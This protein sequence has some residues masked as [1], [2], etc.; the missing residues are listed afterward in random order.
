MTDKSMSPSVSPASLSKKTGVRRVNNLPIFIGVGIVLAFVLI[1]AVVAAGRS[2]D[3]AAQAAKDE[4]NSGNANIFADQIVG[5]RVDGLVMPALEEYKEEQA[6][7]VEAENPTAPFELP[8]ARAN[9]L[10]MPPL[11]EHVFEDEETQRFRMSK[12]QMFEQAVKAKS[13]VS[14]SMPRSTASTQPN[15]NA[16]F[17]NN[18]GSDAASRLAALR[19][20][21]S[22]Q[23]TAQ[24]N[25]D[26]TAAY[27][28]RLNQL[29]SSGIGGLGAGGN[30]NSS[31]MSLLAASNASGGSDYAQ[32]DNQGGDR[33]DLN[34]K[35]QA[36][37]TPFEIRSGFVL[38]ATLISGINSSLSGQI[39]AQVSQNIYDTATGKHLLV[40]QG[41]RLVGS[42]GSDV[43]YGQSRV[44]VGWQRIIF[45]DG[46]A[47]DI[48][49]M[50]GAD[51]AGFAGFNDKTNNH[52]FRVFGSAFLM[53]G[54][55][56]GVALSQDSGNSS[57]GDNQRASDAMSEALG[58]QLGQVTAA[59]IQKNLNIAPTLEIR[60]GYRFNVVVTKDM[61][62]TKAYESFDY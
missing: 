26:P 31:G 18:A 22:Q 62:F 6:A 15:S 9:N 44:L 49:S 35:V 4:K 24:T 2:Q 23:R 10:D 60:P 59:M 38:P 50:S 20:E 5:D 12:M 39:I 30:A 13:T 61:A 37:R 45:P 8:I 19:Q 17:S 7:Y 57:S 46:K 40:P 16:S 47:L 11:P 1:I 54:I 42:Y 52:Y 32:F 21:M 27:Q 48:G 34:T 14:V 56:A 25:T 51:G 29:R 33:W 58:Q 36:P 28:Q 3:S 55:T 41:S 53:S 43:A